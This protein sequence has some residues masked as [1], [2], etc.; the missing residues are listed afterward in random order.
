MPGANPHAGKRARKPCPHKGGA[1]KKTRKQ[2][3]G[4]SFAWLPKSVVPSVHK[5]SRSMVETIELK[6]AAGDTPPANWSIVADGGLVRRFSW[7][8]AG[9]SDPTDFTNLFASYRLTHAEMTFFFANTGSDAAG[10]DTEGLSNRQIIMYAKPNRNGRSD[11]ILTEQH[12]LDNQTTIKKL[13]YNDNAAPVT[14]S[15]PLTQLG[16][17]YAG[18]TSDYAISSPG[19]ISTGEVNTGHYGVDIRLQRVD[20]KEFSSGGGVYPSVKIVTKINLECKQVQ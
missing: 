13:C 2:S 8:L 7:S 4:L 10:G 20:N 9:L 14:I 6:S 5:F 15:L 19:F 3:K 12:Y 1:V 17:K 18:A 16:E 11:Q